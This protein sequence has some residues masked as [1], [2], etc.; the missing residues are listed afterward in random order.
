MSAR[1]PQVGDTITTAEELDLAL[2][3]GP[4]D[5]IWFQ[6]ISTPERGDRTPWTCAANEDGEWWALRLLTDDDPSEWEDGVMLPLDQVPLPIVITATSDTPPRPERE[7]KA[8]AL[9]EAADG[10][11]DA[12]HL[13]RQRDFSLRTFGPG[14][15]TAGVLAH[16][17]KELAEIEAAP[18]DLSEWADVVILAL[19]GAWRTGADPRQ[20]IAA[21][22]AKQA[23]NEARTWPDWRTADPDKPI[24]HVRADR[25]ARGDA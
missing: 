6:C 21:I 18:L 17:R 16:I 20:I 23:R 19:D 11:I 13:A 25:I 1:T 4:L 24:E 15:R 3:E 10:A 9:R 7:V 12:T 8:E 14:A 2:A 5:V 22:K